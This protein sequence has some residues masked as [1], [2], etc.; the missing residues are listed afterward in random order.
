MAIHIVHYLSGFFLCCRYF[1][2]QV[3]YMHLW[4]EQA[5]MP[6]KITRLLTAHGADHLTT[7]IP[8]HVSLPPSVPNDEGYSPYNKPAA[9]DH[10]LREV[11]N[12][13]PAVSGLSSFR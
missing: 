13:L 8:T 9:V 5:K 7:R 2:W 3:R 4:F 11:R 12:I 6:G 10:W 1:E